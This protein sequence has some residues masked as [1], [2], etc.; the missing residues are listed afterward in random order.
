M[1]K[2]NDDDDDISL[3][4]RGEDIRKLSYKKCPEKSVK[5]T[6]SSR[7]NGRRYKEKGEKVYKT[8]SNNAG[9]DNGVGVC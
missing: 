9:W 4:S 1:Q 3:G 7:R 5:T 6:A 2:I 8:V